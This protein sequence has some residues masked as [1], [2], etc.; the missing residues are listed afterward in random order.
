MRLIL[1]GFHEAKTINATM[2][3][4]LIHGNADCTP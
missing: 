1:S 3:D 4:V 2:I